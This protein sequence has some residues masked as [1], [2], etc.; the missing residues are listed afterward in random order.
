MVES[1]KKAKAALII[2]AMKPGKGMESEMGEDEDEDEAGDQAAAK[3]DAAQGVLD[4]LKAGDAKGLVSSLETF[5]SL[6]DY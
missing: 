3:E 6:C 2:A 4:S 5:I 1:D